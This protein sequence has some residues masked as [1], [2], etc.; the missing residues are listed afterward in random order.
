MSGPRCPVPPVAAL[1]RRPLRGACRRA[2]SERR[3][4]GGRAMALPV[5]LQLRYWGIAAAL[6]LALLWVLGDVLLPFLAGGALAYFLDPV[7]DRLERAG[8]SRA[9]SVAVITLATLLVLS[10]ALLIVVPALLRQIAALIEAAPGLLR[11]LQEFLAARAPDLLDAES[12][13]RQS[14]AGIGETIRGRG[15]ELLNGLLGSALGVVNALV[16]LVV[17]P[18]V[19]V[20]L[21]LDWDRMVA[22]LDMLLPREHAPVIRRLAREIDRVLAGFVRGQITV[23]ALLAVYYAAGLGLLG[24]NYGLA[25]GVAAGVLSFIPYVGAITGGVLSIGLALFQFWGDPVWI[26]A[27]A[28]VFVLGQLLEG[29]L[30]VPRLVGG[31]V[32][33]HP[34]WLLLALSVFG[35]LFGFVGMLV[36]VP[37]AAA[38]GVLLRFGVEQYLASK[39]YLGPEPPGPP[40]EGGG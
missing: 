39:L 7:A 36:A 12:S 27:V 17:T 8:L 4:E 34:V 2:M 16:F 10:V 21:L 24:L 9:L 29:N 26:G 35:A 3:T 20:Y 28:A 23:C 30:L 14:L 11:H 31:S 37:V 25:V 15:A 1:M 22:R 19:A 40:T 5:E 13:I 6:F 38:L 32:G 18:V 33:L